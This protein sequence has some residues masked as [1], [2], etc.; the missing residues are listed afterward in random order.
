MRLDLDLIEV[1]CCVY[2]EGSFS[3][4]ASRLYLSQ[5]TI[6]GH[7]KNLE[8][9]IDAKLFDR[10][11]RNLVPTQAGRLLYRHGR[12]ILDEK[13]AAIQ[14]L[15]KF[16]NRV[17]GSL[18]ICASTIPGEYLLPQL[19]AA[20]H[21]R[22]PAVRIEMRI[23]DSESV[24]E[25]ALI[26][27]AEIGFAGAKV[28]SVGL[29]YNLLASDELVLIAPHNDEWRAIE[30]VSLDRLAKM[31]FLA[32]EVGSGTRLIFERKTG[33]SMNG[34][35]IVGYL[36]SSNAI[37]EAVKAGLGAAVISNLAVRTELASGLV[38]TVRIEGVESLNR[39]FYTVVNRNLTL[40]PLAEE[41]L[42]FIFEDEI[43]QAASA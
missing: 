38:K 10:L 7:I 20:F 22:F 4:A 40:S 27:K 30:S 3:K 32:R 17:E 37:K 28:D 41:F 1:F 23:S 31:P 11:P 9:Y 19:I 8:S 24:C 13:R 39:Q 18:R 14:E 21:A 25:E 2:E 12:V 35:N 6:S 5:P 15:K 33:C 43:E 36:S 29:E 42:H 16:L 34:F 26:G